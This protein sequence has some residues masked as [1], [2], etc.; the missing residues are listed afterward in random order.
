MECFEEV[1]KEWKKLMNDHKSIA[2][3]IDLRNEE[4]FS[5]RHLE[6]STNLSWNSIRER[7]YLFCYLKKNTCLL[8]V[9]L[10]ISSKCYKCQ[11]KNFLTC[12]PP[13]LT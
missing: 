7:W 3:I 2:G 10:R 5:S 13:Y 11:I 9:V 8:F 6:Q 1:L 4:E 12:S